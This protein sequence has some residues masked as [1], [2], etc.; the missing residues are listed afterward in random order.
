MATLELQKCPGWCSNVAQYFLVRAPA[1]ILR[2]QGQTFLFSAR[3]WYFSAAW[4]PHL[5]K[6]KNQQIMVTAA[7]NWGCVREVRGMGGYG[8]EEGAWQRETRWW[9][10][11]YKD[12]A[13]PAL[14]NNNQPLENNN[15]PTMVTP[16]HNRQWRDKLG[17]WGEGEKMVEGGM[18]TTK[19]KHQQWQT[20]CPCFARH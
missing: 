4:C 18:S 15:Q 20:P 14:K 10:P 1:E 3:W 8:G 19:A 9:Q 17:R 7:S 5:K 2:P 6:L 13:L 11:Y 16:G 12:Y